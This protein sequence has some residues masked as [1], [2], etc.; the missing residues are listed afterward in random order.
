MAGIF[1]NVTTAQSYPGLPTRSQNPMLQQYFI[2]AMP[3][4]TADQWSF[5]QSLYITNTYQQDINSQQ[6]LLIDVENTRLDLQ[7]TY[8]YN[9]WYFNINLPY[10]SNQPGRLDPL[11]NDW[12]DFF[13]LPEGGRNQAENNRLR[14]Y[15]K[16]KQQV[17]FDI[18]Q[19]SEGFADIQLATGYQLNQSTQLWLAVEVPTPGSAELISNEAIDTALWI[20]SQDLALLQLTAYYALGVAFHSDKGLFK[21]RIRRQSGFAQLG[22][23]YPLYPGYDVLLQAD[24]H[25]QM[26]KNTHLDGLTNSLQAQFVLRLKQLSDQYNLD[27]FFSEDVYP[28]HAPDITFGLRVSPSI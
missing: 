19:P 21:D 1:C 16:D 13:S 7:A 4:T 17:L 11:I 14:L 27:L 9:D 28:G 3:L 20:S 12:H 26:L 22:L 25:T 18:K 8:K 10:I 15:Y 5:S 2:P 6:E 24:M 23:V